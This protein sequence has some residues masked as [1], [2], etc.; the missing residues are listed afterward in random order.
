MIECWIEFDE[1]DLLVDANEMHMC[2]Y[3]FQ[4]VFKLG[5]HRFSPDF[6]I[7]N[8]SNRNFYENVVFFELKK[9][10]ERHWSFNLQKNYIYH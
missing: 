1:L 2:M 9:N 8:S 3:N 6:R 4:I 5:F 10:K 7:S